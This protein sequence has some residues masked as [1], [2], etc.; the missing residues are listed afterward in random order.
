MTDTSQLTA[1]RDSNHHCCKICSLVVTEVPLEVGQG[2]YCPRCEQKLYQSRKGTI[3]VDLAL[4]LTCLILFIPTQLFE[5]VHIRLFGVMI[6]SSLTSGAYDLFEGGFLALSL[7]IFFCCS[8]VPFLVFSSVILSHFA[9]KIRNRALLKLSLFLLRNLKQWVTLDVFLVS[10]AISCFKLKD[11]ADIYF[12]YGLIA[13]IL[14]QLM[15]FLLVIRLDSRNYWEAIKPSLER[16]STGTMLHCH[17]CHLLQPIKTKCDRCNSRL[18]WFKPYS[19]LKTWICVIAAAIALIPA[20]IL[21]ISILLTNGKRLEDTIMSGIFSLINSQMYGIALIIFTASIVVPVAKV[22][23]LSYLLLNI[24]RG[25]D[26]EKRLRTK[27]YLTIKWIGR[28]SM[29]DLFVVAIMITLVDR[30]QILDFTPGYGAVAF[31]IAVVL[32]MIATESLDPK[33]IWLSPPEEKKRELL[34]NE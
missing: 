14:L 2:A 13:I 30:G 16:Q 20:N 3:S 27:L 34:T 7:L 21:P 19:V 8:V 4:A 32:T 28:W 12:G 11:Y 23:G 22:A 1:N 15:T 31:G 24:Q 10:V 18:Y 25:N 5:F 9:L 26:H 17:T 6:S 29:M 33:L